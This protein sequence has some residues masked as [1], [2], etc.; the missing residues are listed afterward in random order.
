MRRVRGVG[1]GEEVGAVEKEC[2]IGVGVPAVEEVLPEARRCRHLRVRN[3]RR[4]Q[5]PR[6]KVA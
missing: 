5:R 1:S 2:G 3:H 6:P 4:R